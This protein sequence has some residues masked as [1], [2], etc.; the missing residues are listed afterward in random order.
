MQHTTCISL[1]AVM[2]SDESIGTQGISQHR[3][4][5]YE[6]GH[7]NQQCHYQSRLHCI[8]H[9]TWN[10]SRDSYLVHENRKLSRCI[11]AQGQ[12]TIF[13]ELAGEEAASILAVEVRE[14]KELTE[15]ALQAR[16]DGQKLINLEKI[17][18]AS[19]N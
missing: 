17:D 19:K 14:E 9:Q 5:K 1:L 2:Q 8:G 10:T 18:L 16:V 15:S 3:I 11:R 12:I 7:N 13:Q 4:N 6:H